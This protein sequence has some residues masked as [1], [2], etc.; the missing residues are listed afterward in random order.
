MQRLPLETNYFEAYNRDNV[1]PGRHHRRPD[2]ADHPETGIETADGHHE[3]DIIVYATGFNAITG[4]YD[5]DRDPR[6]RT[7][8]TLGDKWRDSPSTYLGV[9]S[10]GFPN[11]F[12]VAGPQSVSGSTNF[13][14]AI[15]TG[16]DWV[17]D[18]LDY[19]REQ[20]ATR[21]EADPQA[22]EQW[23]EEV[24]RAHERML[25]RRSKGWFTG[26]NSNVEGHEAGKVRY[27]AYFG[28]AP[29]YSEKITEAVDSDY[30]GLAIE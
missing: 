2:P 27:Q 23:V 16:V 14:R 7:V 4:G 13:P 12:M 5:Q 19:V 30:A 11:M 29:R 3:L 10:H 20:G 18:L 9:F 17:T 8:E 28:G 1:R 26:Y 25:F 6:R 22:E 21:I 24:T 15:E